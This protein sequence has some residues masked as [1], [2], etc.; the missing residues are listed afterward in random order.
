VG[1]EEGCGVRLLSPV[2][3]VV[4]GIAR[5]HR[6]HDA[7]PVRH[8]TVPRHHHRPG[9]GAVTTFTGDTATT[10]SPAYFQRIRASA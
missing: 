4:D 8:S 1:K 7:L 10:G 2:D 5:R 9:L 3:M 6:L